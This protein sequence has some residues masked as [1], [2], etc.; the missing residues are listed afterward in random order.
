M[1]RDRSW[2]RAKLCGLRALTP[3]IA[4]LRSAPALIHCGRVEPGYV[5]IVHSFLSR[6]TQKY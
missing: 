4:E 5:Q 2:R 3:L 1:N 6:D